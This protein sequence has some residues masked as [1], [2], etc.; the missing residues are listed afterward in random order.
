MAASRPWTATAKRRPH[1]W[2][3]VTISIS[4]DALAAIEAT[5]PEGREAER[6]PDGKGGYFITLPHGVVD[7]RK[8]MR[9]PGESY[10]GSALQSL[11]AARHPQ[12]DIGI[13]F[14]GAAHPRQAIDDGLRQPDTV[15]AIGRGLQRSDV[16]AGG[17]YR[18]NRRVSLG[19]HG[20]ADHRAPA[21]DLLDLDSAL[22]PYH[23][24]T[25]ENDI[26]PIVAT[27]AHATNRLLER[28]E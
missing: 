3:V 15:L 13:A 27:A 4:A 2:R 26:S 10:S 24:S 18:G 1:I 8:A 6:R 9:G 14:A 5:L 16:D 21:G 11:S 7:R 28:V 22:G 17:Q 12:N 20:D 25:I 19:G 23:R